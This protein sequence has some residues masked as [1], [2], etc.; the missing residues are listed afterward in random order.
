MKPPT[1]KQKIQEEF[2]KQARAYA[3]NAAISDGDR[4]LRLVNAV[5]PDP[6]ARV[7]E[8]ATGPGYVA[9]AFAE[10]CREVIGVDLTEAPLVIAEENRRA[11]GINN[12]TFRLA[13]ADQLQFADGELDVVV[14]RLA[15]HHFEFPE[16]TLKEMTRVCR[17]DGLVAIEDLAVSEHPGRAD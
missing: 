9:M 6:S 14:C 8:I 11:R 2:T 10:R 17:A 4:L 13:D 3:S 1:H 5:N 16:A 15:I 7:L 12:V